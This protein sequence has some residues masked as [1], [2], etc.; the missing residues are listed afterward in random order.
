VALENCCRKGH[1]PARLPAACCL[2]PCLQALE[3]LLAEVQRRH[4]PR[5]VNG[6]QLLQELEACRLL[7]TASFEPARLAPPLAVG[8]WPLALAANRAWACASTLEEGPAAPSSQQHACPPY[9]VP[10]QG[11]DSIDATLL[12]G[13]LRPGQVVELCG[14]SGGWVEHL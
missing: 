8:R 1:L 3:A 13:G 2:P 12:S 14:E 7:G 10:L 5:V 9:L 4:A 11:C 6:Q